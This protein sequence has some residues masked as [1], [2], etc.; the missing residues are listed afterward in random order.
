MSVAPSTHVGQLMLEPHHDGSEL[1]VL[2]RPDE[3]GGDAT[4]RVRTPRG[5]AD[6]VLLRYSRDGE[7]RTV[8]AMVDEETRARDVVARNLP[9]RQPG[10][11]LPLAARGRRRPATAG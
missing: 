8:E 10:D 3:L 9:G 11:A 1:H 6:R 7:P 5:A 2:E 4:V